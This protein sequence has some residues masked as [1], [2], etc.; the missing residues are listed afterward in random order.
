MGKRANNEGSIYRRK[1][2]GKWVASITLDNGRRKVLY[3]DT[4]R[5][6][7]EKL[8][9][10]RSE[11]QQGIL[12][13]DAK[14]KLS[15]Y[16]QN[17]LESYRRTVRPN[18]HQRACEMI[19]LHVLPTLGNLQLD[20]LTPQHLDRL[21]KKLLETLSPT[22]VQNVHNTLHKALSDAVKQ[23]ILLMNVSERVEAPRRNECEARVLTEEEM[24]IFLRASKNHPLYVLMLI[25]LSTGMRRGEV[26]GLKWSDLDLKKGIVQVRR[27][28]VRHPTE[29]GG[30]YAEAPLKTKRSRRS[31]IL[32]AYIVAV[33]EQYRAQQMSLV[34]NAGQAWNEQRWL[35]CKP[36]SSHLNPQNDVYEAFKE[37]L[38][39]A[40]LPDIHFHDL[41]Y[42][43]ATTHLEM[44]TNPK[45]VQEIL[46]HSNISITMDP[47]SHV[48]PPM[49]KDAMDNINEW[50]LSHT[51]EQVQEEPKRADDD[52]DNG[53]GN[54]VVLPV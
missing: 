15:E 19:N 32:P 31:I 13:T 20:K 39:Q 1:S 37:L 53:Q 5:E 41:R 43:A 11:Q 47:Y 35:F 8:I 36:D 25:D 21:Y 3:G 16:I 10:V 45:I 38:K 46:G 24:Q 12:P 49:H 22:T 42:T 50:L 48:L 7:T 26:V 18:S 23:G 54:G 44:M 52:D 9:K 14:T 4:K 34:Q 17:W 40:G 27:A 51:E 28:I 2:D 29:Q 30:G 6:V 33:L